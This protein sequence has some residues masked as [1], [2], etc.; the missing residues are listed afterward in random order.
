VD[1][2]GRAGHQPRDRAESRLSAVFL[3]RDGVINRKRPEGSYVT[4]WDEFEFLPNA[5]E[6]LAMLARAAVPVIVVT[7]Q[8]GIARGAMTAEDLIEIHDRLRAT[9]GA[10]GGRLD[11]I[12]HC[13]HE[14][15]CRCRKPEPGMFED[16][17]VDFGIRLE[18]T[19][20]IGD[21]P[22]DMAAAARIGALQVLVAGDGTAA[23]TVD[24]QISYVARDLLDAVCWLHRER[25]LVLDTDLAAGT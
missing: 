5:L 19:A 3:D 14:G 1:R 16:A 10:A 24:P 20:V 23:R 11:A 22:S 2:P 9:A 12:Y 6:G 13:P 25:Y 17:A 8:R 4:S 7:N 21:Q 18:E 15:P